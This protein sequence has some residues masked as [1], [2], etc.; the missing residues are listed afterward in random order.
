MNEE[1]KIGYYAIIP[2][3][4]LFD[5]KLKA[6]EKLM[7]AAITVLSNKEGYC[8]ASNAYLG[9]LFDVADHTA[10]IWVN[11]LKRSG[12][13]DVQILYDAKGN[14]VQRRIYPNDRPYVINNTYPY[15][16]KN[17][18]GMSQIVKDN[19]ISINKIDR[20]FNYII[21]KENEFPEEFRNTN[22]NEIE[23][24]LERY[25]MKYTSEVLEYISNSNLEK[26]KNIVYAV[27]L[28]AKDNLQHLNYKVSR[29]KLLKIYND[30]KEKEE[31]YKGSKN[32]IENFMNY[33]YKS[34][35]NELTKE[36]KSP[37]FFIPKNDEIEDIGGLDI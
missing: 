30:C 27:C 15:V 35:V 11:S 7:Y 16:T 8:F 13:V 2:A 24:L 17:T 10:S 12:F 20:L 36:N 9:K 1:N 22:F 34:I 26:I 21:N 29:D 23:K 28:I 31:I 18:E 25:E 19:N 14:F 32:E 37:S 5:K 4:V 6:S 3:T 33:Y